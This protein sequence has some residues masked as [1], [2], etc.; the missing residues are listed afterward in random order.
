VNGKSDS[1]EDACRRSGL[2]FA[3]IQKH[4]FRIRE[5]LAGR[6]SGRFRIDTAC[7]LDNAGIIVTEAPVHKSLSNE[8]LAAVAFVPAAG[9]ASRFLE[10]LK[11]FSAALTD[12]NLKQAAQFGAAAGSPALPLPIK[13]REF[14]ENSGR[15]F[16]QGDIADLLEI[17][18]W[19]KALF[20]CNGRGVSFLEAKALE[21]AAYKKAG[22][23]FCGEVYVAPISRSGHF[24]DK[25]T[26]S[27]AA[28][29]EQLPHEVMEQDASL[30]TLRF[31]QDGSIVVGK[32]GM[33][34]MV[35]AGHGALINLFGGVKKKFP[36]AEYLLIRNVD[37]V[38][39]T[40]VEASQ[41]VVRF[42]SF[43]SSMIRSVRKVRESLVQR[44]F[45][46]TDLMEAIQFLTSL[47]LEKKA[48]ESSDLESITGAIK[49][50]KKIQE[51]VFHTGFPQDFHVSLPI[52]LQIDHLAR[53]FSRPVNVLGQVPN[54][55]NDV[56]GT[57]VFVRRP[58]GIKEKLCIEV[59]HVD[60]DQV[61]SV[62]KNPSVATHFNPVFVASEL[63]ADFVGYNVEHP[64]WSC[65]RKRFDGADVYY[66]ESFLYEILGSSSL[67]NAVFIEIPRLLFNPHKTLSDAASAQVEI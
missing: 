17:L 53:L 64:Y 15:S 65:V 34:S 31:R 12:G 22:V 3:D 30:S 14:I 46:G 35:A 20:P 23:N 43:A 66:Y 59:V 9:A 45:A 13:L 54:S 62:L 27:K 40:G 51:S 4:D 2:S 7:R 37:N 29:Q 38:C 28:F 57:P 36:R 48:I 1:L 47:Q 18:S 41:A 44:Q 21:H 5:T 6:S 16:S 55:G 25:L 50:F 32:N 33:P 24:S 42:S 67:S 39:G 63:V 58:D 8:Q 61:E 19:P 56:G 49:V 60:G 52:D 26:A 11:A 10:P